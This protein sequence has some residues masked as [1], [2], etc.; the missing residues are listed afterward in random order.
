MLISVL[1][2]LHNTDIFQLG[3]SSGDCNVYIHSSWLKDSRREQNNMLESE[4]TIHLR[5]AYSGQSKILCI[6]INVT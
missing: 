3:I 1:W 6:R 5:G 2:K 4:E